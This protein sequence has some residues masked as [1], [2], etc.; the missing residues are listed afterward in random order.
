VNLYAYGSSITGN[1]ANMALPATLRVFHVGDTGVSGDISGMSIAALTIFYVYQTSVTYGT[2][3]TAFD[4][5]TGTPSVEAQDCGWTA[6]MV[7]KALSNANDSTGASGTTFYIGGTNTVPTAAGYADQALLFGLG[8]ILDWTKALIIKTNYLA[9]KTA[10][11]IV[12]A[13]LADDQFLWTRPDGTTSASKTP[14]AAFFNASGVYTVTCT[15]WSLV[16]E[17]HFEQASAM[18]FLLLSNLKVAF[19]ALTGLTSLTAYYN[20]G[21]ADTITYWV[22]PSSLVTM[23]FAY[24]IVA[25]DVSNL[26]FPPAML[27]YNVGFA[28]VGYGLLGTAFSTIPDTCS[29]VCYGCTWSVAYVDKS[30]VDAR[31]SSAQTGTE[32][33]LGGNSPPTGGVANPDVVNLAQR[34]WIITLTP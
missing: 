19:A 30:L 7:D 22:L 11:T 28:P 27:V 14:T 24:T 1:I 8:W 31:A 12:A 33:N 9:V 32:I 13:S 10:P 17:L 4:Q 23:H 21:Y 18:N 15:D 5:L 2:A 26:Y 16:T 6:T 20:S 34:G 29:V 25:G 3:G